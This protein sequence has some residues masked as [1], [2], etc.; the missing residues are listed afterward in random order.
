MILENGIKEETSPLELD[1]YADSLSISIV[2]ETNCIKVEARNYSFVRT[3]SNS[4][5]AELHSNILIDCLES[6]IASSLMP[7]MEGK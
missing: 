1:F 5:L 6:A 2:Q 3:K 7:S 4:S